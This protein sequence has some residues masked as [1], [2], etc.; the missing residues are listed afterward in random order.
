MRHIVAEWPQTRLNVRRVV[1][2]GGPGTGKT[3]LL[4]E[5]NQLGYATVPE[6]ARVVI[7][8]RKQKGLAPRPEPVE[9]AMEILRSDM[10]QYESA[11]PNKSDLVFFDRGVL[12]ALGMLD[13]IDQL[14]GAER[15]RYLAR[16]P[17]YRKAFIL[18]PWREIYETDAERDQSYADAVRVHVRLLHWY[19]QCGYQL[20]ELAA[21]PV[22]ERCE[23]VLR[24]LKEIRDDI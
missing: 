4:R 24:Q 14:P 21:A 6:A 19:S 15:E 10:K 7:Q 18:P 22:I 9:F 5:L 12:D 8:S 20:V 2:T 17:Y 11:T 13:E 3:T 23:F 16:Y 1:L